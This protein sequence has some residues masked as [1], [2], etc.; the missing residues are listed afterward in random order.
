MYSLG[1]TIRA[2]A[3]G[4]LKNTDPQRLANAKVALHDLLIAM[5]MI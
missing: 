1:L 2:L 4:D 5:M 3:T